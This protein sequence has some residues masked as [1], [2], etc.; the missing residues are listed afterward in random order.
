MQ[1]RYI[2]EGGRTLRAVSLFWMSFGYDVLLLDGNPPY[3]WPLCMLRWLWPFGACQLISVDIMFVQPVGW[4]QRL[5][6]WG[7]KLLLKRV[8]HFIHYFKDLDAYRRYFGISEDRSTY[9]PFKVNSWE[10]MPPASELSADGDYVFTGGR[11]L[12]DTDTFLQA[13]RRV[14]Y[15]AVLL[16]HDP[17]RMETDGTFLAL[18]DLPANVRAVEDNGSSDSWLDHLRRAKLVVIAT[19]PSSIRAIGISS[20][21][22]A[23]ALRKCVII[24]AGPATKNILT[25]EAIIVPPGDPAALTDAVRRAWED[26]A[27]RETTA[28]AGRRYAEHLGGVARFVADIIVVCNQVVGKRRKRKAPEIR[29]REV[30]AG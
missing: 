5:A 19:L 16:Y 25:D 2:R 1:H 24:T 26:A 12:R 23:M 3:L 21:L 4:K 27:L 30:R 29:P 9:V 14:N 6:A 17:K 7:R 10:Q 28:A 22:V 13:M 18:H 11:S 20:Y 15:P 8:D